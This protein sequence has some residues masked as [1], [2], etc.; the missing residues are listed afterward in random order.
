MNQEELLSKKRALELYEIG[1]NMD[2]EVGTTAGLQQIHQYL[3]QDIFDFAGQIR[4]VN[5]A[6]GNMRFA[7]ILFLEQ[8][9]KTI[10]TLPETTFEEIITKYVEMNIAHPFR[11]GNGRAT[12]IWLDQILKKSLKKCVDWSK[13]D[14]SE[15][16]S[17]MERSPVNQLEIQ[18]LLRHNLTGQIEDREVYMKGIQ[19]SY[20]Y[21]DMDDYDVH[22]L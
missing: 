9:L 16:L 20:Q 10:D 1:K 6:K 22:T 18:E 13:I 4:T 2:F 7:P 14:K 17:A 5:I 15:Y 3:F 11:E 12:R 21:E 19:A 8:N